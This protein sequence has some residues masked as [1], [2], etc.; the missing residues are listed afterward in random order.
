MECDLRSIGGDWVFRSP[1]SLR[2]IL[3]FL[4]NSGT[5]PC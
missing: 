3:D 1:S 2:I 4:G 5:K